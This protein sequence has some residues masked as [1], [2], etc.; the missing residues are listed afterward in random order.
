MMTQS[1][2]LSYLLP[3]W[4]MQLEE[5]KQGEELQDTTSEEEATSE[6]TEEKKTEEKVEE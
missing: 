6:E 3:E 2:R 4:L 5:V 1:V